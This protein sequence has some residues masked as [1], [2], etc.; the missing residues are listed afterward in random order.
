[1]EKH[2]E[3]ENQNK[4]HLIFIIEHNRKKKNDGISAC[5]GVN[6]WIYYEYDQWSWW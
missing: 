2:L 3:I 1:M 6:V 4:M 5:G